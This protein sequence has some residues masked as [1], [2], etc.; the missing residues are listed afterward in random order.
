M[1]R[2]KY[3]ALEADPRENLKGKKMES[4]MTKRRSAPFDASM[5][6][7]PLQVKSRSSD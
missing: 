2:R 5:N 1:K 4:V 6:F 7:N 3:R